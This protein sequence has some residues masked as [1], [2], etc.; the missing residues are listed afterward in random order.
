M[1]H[2]WHRSATSLTSGEGA[3]LLG[4]GLTLLSEHQSHCLARCLVLPVPCP[5]AMLGSCFLPALFGV[6]PWEAQQIPQG[7]GSPGSQIPNPHPFPDPPCLSICLVWDKAWSGKATP[8]HHSGTWFPY[9][10]GQ[11]LSKSPGSWAAHTGPRRCMPGDGCGRKTATPAGFNHPGC[12]EDMGGIGWG[13]SA[14]SR[15]IA[16]GWMFYG[17]V[18]REL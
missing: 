6:L 15:E 17:N 13:G 10:P 4:L 12:A 11:T 7:C 8:C 9:L 18:C 2:P 5:T 1:T 16:P 14:G 3:V